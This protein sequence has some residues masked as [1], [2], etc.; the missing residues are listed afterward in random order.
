MHANT[1]S[2]IRRAT[3]AALPWCVA[4]RRVVCRHRVLVLLDGGVRM[5]VPDPR[6]HHDRIQR[7]RLAVEEK[8]A[9][10]WP[11]RG[12]LQALRVSSGR[13]TRRHSRRGTACAPEL[14][15]GFLRVANDQ[16]VH[17]DGEPRDGLGRHRLGE[18][19]RQSK[20]V[21]PHLKLGQARHMD[22]QAR[23]VERVCF[24]D[25]EPKPSTIYDPDC[26]RV[27][28]KATSFQRRT[29]EMGTV[30]AGQGQARFGPPAGEE[31][32]GLG[33]QDIQVVVET[34]RLLDKVQRGLHMPNAVRL[35]TWPCS[36]AA[37]TSLAGD[38]GPRSC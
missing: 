5:A 27:R 37:R 30:P 33:H 21:V 31:Q 2:S 13:H 35:A 14:G 10:Q 15:A 3:R 32:F 34:Q 17:A 1:T 9:Q 26:T 36:S 18:P 16:V 22:E 7:Q 8:K 4:R 6:R 29:L 23:R 11:D 25:S 24:H 20:E 19:V 38:N 12:R 28:A